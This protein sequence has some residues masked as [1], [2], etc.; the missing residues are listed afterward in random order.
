MAA[1]AVACSDSTPAV[2]P[3]AIERPAAVVGGVPISVG[4]VRAE[5]EAGGGTPEE[6]LERAIRRELLLAY[7]REN[8]I[9]T[10]PHDRAERRTMVRELLER[11]VEASVS[12]ADIREEDVRAAFEAQHERFHQPE[13]RTAVH[14]LAELE[15]TSTPAE[16]EAAFALARSVIAEAIVAPD[17]RAVFDARAQNLEGVTVE[18]LG[19]FDR[20]ANFVEEFRAPVFAA[21]SAG[22]MPEPVRSEF[23]VH[24]V[25]I[26]RIVPP[27]D[28]P[29]ELVAPMLRRELLVTRRAEALAALEARLAGGSDVE[30][31]EPLLRSL[32]DDFEQGER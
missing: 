26:V 12:A 11:T 22:V 30:I 25:W 14:F 10:A 16:V 32:P 27:D 3:V 31:D 20:E 29:Y 13:E 24:V 6:A 2:T 28:M 4:D 21:P 19:T 1:L 15:E 7:A 23:G 17:P 5:M 9:E 8:G 18:D